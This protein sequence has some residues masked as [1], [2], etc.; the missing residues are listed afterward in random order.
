MEGVA[1]GNL[2]MTPWDAQDGHHGGGSTD[3]SQ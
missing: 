1:V 3:S 2:G